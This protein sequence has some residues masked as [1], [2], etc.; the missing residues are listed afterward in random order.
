MVIFMKNKS[1]WN[2]EQ[3]PNFKTLTN[4]I[5]TEVLIIGGGIAG[6]LCAYEL[7]KRKINYILVEKDQ[8][9]SHTTKNTT[10]FITAFHETL[11]QD[12]IQKQGVIKAKQYLELNLQALKKYEDLAKQYDFDYE[13]CSATLYSSSNQDLILKEQEALEQL[14]YQTTIV[15]QLPL[16]TKISLGLTY[17]NQAIINPYKLIKNIV[18]DLN[19]Y[20]HT[21]IIKIKKNIAITTNNHQ[22][23][24]KQLVIAT[25]YPIL[26]KSTL[27]FMKIT[28]KRS[29]VA[30]VKHSKIDGTY[31][32]IDDGGLYFRS[33]GNYLIIGGNDRE[34]KKECISDFR[35]RIAPLIKDKQLEFF[36]SGQDAFTLDGIPYIGK[37]DLLHPNYY[38]I[39][40][41]GF[42]GFTW[43][44]VASILIAD[45][46]EGKSQHPLV[47]PMRITINKTLG[48]NLVNSVK[49]LITFKKPRCAHL[50]C[51]LKY[52]EID[53]T[54]E[55]PCHGSRYDQEGNLLDGP[56]QKGITNQLYRKE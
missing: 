47:N 21:K 42:W 24:F 38:V 40:G 53:Q 22:I 36:W 43:S 28:Q 2:Q 35:Q 13:K 1:I 14:G 50:G 49:H 3:L 8:I 17:S 29:Y 23:K 11:Y 5:E 9:A 41:F 16:N 51:A 44:M 37:Y 10:A 31:C 52:N 12:L 7:S 26:N 45:M 34:H 56:A 4:N 46:L 30:A 25:N 48:E 27:N 15:N 39:T 55:C 18:E 54:W 32:D 20:E 19:I 6:I 33:Q